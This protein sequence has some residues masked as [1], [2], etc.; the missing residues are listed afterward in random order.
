MTEIKGDYNDYV[1]SLIQNDIEHRLNLI[2]DKYNIN[3]NYNDIGIIRHTVSE[4]VKSSEIDI[5]CYVIATKYIENM[6]YNY[7]QLDKPIHHVVITNENILLNFFI[8]IM[9]ASKILQDITYTN[10]QYA[11]MGNILFGIK[12]LN[13]KII[14][15]HEMFMYKQLDY[16][17]IYSWV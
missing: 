11:H 8:A 16:R 9:A 12:W 13:L 15:K 3:I 2:S 14:N 10:K 4:L 1:V 6:L 17:L 5:N 7:H